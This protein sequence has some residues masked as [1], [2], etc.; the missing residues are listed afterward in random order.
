MISCFLLHFKFYPDVSLRDY[1]AAKCFATHALQF[2]ANE[3]IYHGNYGKCH[4]KI[5]C[6]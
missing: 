6:T 5:Q 3:Q 1:I 4:T 2:Q